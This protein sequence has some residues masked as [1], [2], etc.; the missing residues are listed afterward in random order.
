MTDFPNPIA[1]MGAYFGQH[2]RPVDAAGHPYLEASGVGAHGISIGA[3]DPA[4]PIT[5]DCLIVPIRSEVGRGQAMLAISADGERYY[6]PGLS[7]AGGHHLIGDAAGEGP[8]VLA[9]DY[10]TAA[11]IHEDSGW[12]VIMTL[13][14]DNLLAVAEWV[15]RRFAGREIKVVADHDSRGFAERAAEIVQGALM[16]PPA[17]LAGSVTPV[18]ETVTEAEHADP[19]TAAIMA[20]LTSDAVTSRGCVLTSEIMAALGGDPEKRD[21]AGEMRVAGY[22]RAK[23]WT[24]SQRRV[25][26]RR[27][28]WWSAPGSVEVSQPV[29][30]EPQSA[31]AAD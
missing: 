2:A 31:A 15:A 22:L 12:P 29:G 6:W 18:G 13:E 19:E 5:G 21:A 16:A 10:A 27:A 14:A 7:I 25:D 30:A 9:V 3:A 4:W 20:V 17:W 28:H 24:R 8:I 1:A 23:G 11:M 26:G